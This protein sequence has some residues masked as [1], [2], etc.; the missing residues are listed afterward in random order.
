MYKLL[1]CMRY[2]KTR[3]IA[4]ASIVSVMLG[5]ATM[6][7]VNSVMSGFSNEMR[8]RI[9]GILADIII[10][11]NSLN[12]ES[13]VDE[14]KA[15]ARQVGGDKIEWIS[16][17]VEVF[18]LLHFKRGGQWIPRPITLV[19]ID[20]AD[21]AK[22]G[23]LVSNLDSYQDIT[24]DGITI[25]KAL[26]EPTESLTWDL[27]AGALAYR[28]EWMQR[29]RDFMQHWNNETVS[30]DS[31]LMPTEPVFDTPENSADTDGPVFES[32]KK[33]EFPQKSVAQGNVQDGPNFVPPGP[34]DDKAQPKPQGPALGPISEPPKTEIVQTSGVDDDRNRLRQAANPFGAEQAPNINSLLGNEEK[35]GDINDPLRCRIYIGAGLIEVLRTHRKTGDVSIERLVNPGDDVKISTVSAGNPPEPRHFFAT[36]ADV[37][38]SGMSEYDS[39]LV[40]CNIEYLQEMRGMIDPET[41][42]GAVTT[43]KIKLKNYDQDSVEVVKKLKNVFPPHL[44]TVRTWEQKQGPLL[45]AVDIE[46]AILN[47]LLFLIIAVAGFGIL[48]I[49]FMIVVEKTRDIGILKALGASSKGVMSIFI[50]YGLALGLVGSGV[51]VV[52]GLVFVRYINEIEGFLSVILGRKVFD[53][54]IYYFPTIPAEVNYFAVSWVAF[55]AV[56]IA[57]L[58]S[59]LPARRAAR[60]HPVQALR[61]E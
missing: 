24:E 2:L 17:N 39:N 35:K 40:F 6:I 36:V 22:I 54:R 19:G 1:L 43:L 61:Y 4:M 13:N 58:A 38:K 51:G 8:S 60:L 23:P 12:G 5:V 16:A 42:K 50:S 31:A 52:L 9:N 37:Y 18:G 48:A 15:I 44:Y 59:V 14:L 33:S 3:Y 11:T 46:A 26:R 45:A 32:D 53:E 47:V 28:A 29:Q 56:A 49:F 25:R 10:E 57:V 30:D 27:T 7:V 55:G 21:E 34:D 41:G 20:P